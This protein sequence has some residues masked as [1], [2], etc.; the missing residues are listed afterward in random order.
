MGHSFPNKKKEMC[1]ELF[2]AVKSRI[3]VTW[4]TTYRVGAAL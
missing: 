4:I 2:T 1:F 3:V